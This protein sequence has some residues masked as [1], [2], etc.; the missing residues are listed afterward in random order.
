MLTT[1]L[2]LLVL[3]GVTAGCLYTPDASG[4]AVVPDGVT[5]IGYRAFYECISL[6]SIALPE[7]LTSIGNYAF[8]HATF[9]AKVSFHERLTS[10]GS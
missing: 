8:T 10:I 4:H 3:G 2:V 6:I 7:G 9:V 1:I 5:S